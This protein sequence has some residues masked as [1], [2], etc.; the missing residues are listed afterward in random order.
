MEG[1]KGILALDAA[2]APVYK[3]SAPKRSLDSSNS[4][5]TENEEDEVTV[6][7]QIE[8]KY[9]DDNESDQTQPFVI[10]GT[11]PCHMASARALELVVLNS[12]RINAC[13][14]LDRLA[15][16]L[17][18]VLEVDLSYN[19]ISS[20]NTIRELLEQLP[21]LKVF[22]ISQNPLPVEI[23]CE[24]PACNRLTALVLNGNCPSPKNLRVVISKMPF[25]EELHLADND[26]RPAAK[27]EDNSPMSLTINVL[28]ISNCCLET[29][30]DAIGVLRLFPKC[31]RLVIGS[32]G[33]AKITK[34][35]S[36]AKHMTSQL[37]ASVRSLCLNGCN[38][39]DWDSIESILLFPALLDL[40]IRNIP[41]FQE[42]SDE[43]RHHLVV[44]R[45]RSLKTLNGS[46]LTPDCREESERFFLR[47]YQLQQVKPDVYNTLVDVHGHVE[48]LAEIDMTP[49]KYASVE[50]S[51]EE[52]GLKKCMQVK[53]AITVQS[54]KT[55]AEQLT[56]ISA[57]AMRVFY[58]DKGLDGHNPNLLSLPQQTLAALHINDGDRFEIQS[59]LSKRPR[60][61]P[62]TKTM[63]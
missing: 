22:N 15:S 51:C 21:A 36:A 3:R 55:K 41:L 61:P 10:F 58:F 49:K 39:K 26:L 34:T 28:N 52:T 25:L 35:C 43:E 2:Q 46:V 62:I 14:N 12:M 16:H 59:K 8:K 24:L 17:R 7:G 19:R 4:S 53:L 40:R 60:K 5:D 37:V 45:L 44:G 31:V 9:L 13:G 6:L 48:Q 20:W 38:F 33:F 32:N 27:D 47:F 11:S 18:R 23:N 54:L 63:K 29:W 42:M 30:D 50:F 57:N 56:G 1:P